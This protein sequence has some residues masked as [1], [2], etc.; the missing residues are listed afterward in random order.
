MY[1]DKDSKVWDAGG[2]LV[3]EGNRRHSCLH[4]LSKVSMRRWHLFC[5]LR[6][7]KDSVS[8]P[9]PE[10][11]E[12]LP[13]QY[14]CSTE[15][16]SKQFVVCIR[17]HF[18]E[19]TWSER[20]ADS[21]FVY[22]TN[23]VFC[24]MVLGFSRKLRLSIVRRPRM[25]TDELAFLLSSAVTIFRAYGFSEPYFLSWNRTPWLSPFLG[26]SNIAAIQM[27]AWQ[28][29]LWVHL[30]VQPVFT[31]SLSSTVLLREWEGSNGNDCERWPQMGKNASHWEI[32]FK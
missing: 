24:H 23:L 27:R 32:N 6:G 8:R 30:A 25:E 21:F 13:D 17:Q 10:F 26:S 5:E 16:L 22:V 1:C 18:R 28:E 2:Q 15:F 14:I 12:A 4:G 29:S 11:S 9:F 7:E 31:S 3:G 20:T 19:E